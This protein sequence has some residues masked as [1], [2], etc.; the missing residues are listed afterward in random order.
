MDNLNFSVDSALLSE[1][2]EKLVESV[3]IALVELIKN[4]YDADA[5]SVKVT[6]KKENA[7]EGDNNNRALT[8]EIADNGTGMTFDE[9]KRYWMRIATTNKIQNNLSRNYGRPKTGAK[10]IGRF[11][12]RRLG[13]KLILQT[14][15]K[16]GNGQYEKTNVV[17]QWE[18]FIAGT[19]VTEIT[20]PGVV[21][22]I[23]QAETGT[24]LTITGQTTDEWNEKKFDYL[25][26]QLSL[27]VVNRGAQR[28]G[29]L[30]NPG[31]N[32][33]LNSFSGTP[34]LKDLREEVY[35]AGWGTLTGDIN[36][37]EL[38]HII[39]KQKVSGKRLLRLKINIII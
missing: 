28:N 29:Y 17:F 27:L 37:S 15:A 3:H 19:N 34:E 13:T 35:N 18:K 2:G 14:I 11:C 23:I 12:C 22:K 5:T 10:G 8:L 20:C 25:M 6:F 16:L 32:I 30:Y 7:A 9:V 24:T 1:L 21:E 39:L 33:I 4:S 36:K 38:L 26:R 31:F